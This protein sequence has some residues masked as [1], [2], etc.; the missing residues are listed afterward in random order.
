MNC[1]QFRLLLDEQLDGALERSVEREC[2]SHIA[3]CATC[4][5][6]QAEAIQL[7]EA[8][9]VLPAPALSEAFATRA[10]AAARAAHPAAVATA[11]A[12][13]RRTANRWSGAFAMAATLVLTLG[14]L[15]SREPLPEIQAV[16]DQPVRLVFRS[17]SAVSD[18]TIE[19]NLPEGVEL[20]G[21][22]GQRTL[23]WQSD[24]QAGSNLLELPVRV[25]GAGGVVTAT[26]NHG[27]DRRQFSVRLVAARDPAAAPLTHAV[28][29]DAPAV[30]LASSRGDRG[31]A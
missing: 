29:R 31:H 6:R 10:F 27:T 13:T 21:Y 4:A 9:A 11:V 26:I 14:I 8:L 22:P 23:V 15:N 1:T 3:A 24:L 18:V 30:A 16:A 19:L 17:E 5:A 25:N 2:L 12:S 7:Q 20:A 28:E